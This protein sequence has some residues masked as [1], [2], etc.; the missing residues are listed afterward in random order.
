MTEKKTSEATAP[1]GKPAKATE[2]AAL[3]DEEL[4]KATGGDGTLVSSIQ[5]TEHDT[6]SSNIG[7][8]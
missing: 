7:K 5:K 4:N 8:L 6:K 3:T 2:N 1:V